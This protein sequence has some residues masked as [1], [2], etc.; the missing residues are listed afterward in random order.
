VFQEL[1]FVGAEEWY[2]ELS[3]KQAH[4]DFL[5]ID[6]RS[7]EEIAASGKIVDAK[8]FES[9]TFDQAGH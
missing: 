8:T 9:S 3:S 5:V 1:K 6:V 4:K 7:T 2:E